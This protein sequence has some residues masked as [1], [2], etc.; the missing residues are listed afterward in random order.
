[1]TDAVEIG[2]GA[3]GLYMTYRAIR[4]FGYLFLGRPG[5]NIIRRQARRR[6]VM[7][8]HLCRQPTLVGYVGHKFEAHKQAAFLNIQM[9]TPESVSWAG[10]YLQIAGK[11][12]FLIS[13]D[14]TPFILNKL[15]PNKMQI[16][17]DNRAKKRRAK[18]GKASAQRRQERLTRDLIMGSAGR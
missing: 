18:L 9:A 16:W 4:G 5:Y 17:K 2:G 12:L 1:M 13:I 10:H 8:R 11:K 6:A 14:I 3:V 7:W 15:M